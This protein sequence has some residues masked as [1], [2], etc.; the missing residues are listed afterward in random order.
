MTT[1]EKFRQVRN[2]YDAA[3]EKMPEE[4]EAFLEE[5]C[6]GD[7]DLLAELRALIE[8]VNATG[9]SELEVQSGGRTFR[10]GRNGVPA[11]APAMPYPVAAPA[12]GPAATAPPA[13]AQRKLL[14]VKSPIVGTFYRAP[15]PDAEPYVEEGNRI[16]I[17][18]TVC[19]VEAMKL[20]NEVA[21]P[22][23]GKVAELACENGE[24]VEF[25]Q[26][27]MYLEPVD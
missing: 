25:E 18:Q 6:A 14:A 10:V 13:E 12:A 9:I 20:M 2:L 19:I 17:G 7:P 5:A 15:A 23:K 22:E 1:A 27:L 11:M 26:V 21:A 8:L 24:P 16:G 4:Q 3:V